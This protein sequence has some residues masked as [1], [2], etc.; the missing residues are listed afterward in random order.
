M[1]GILRIFFTASAVL[2]LAA[3]GREELQS[4]GSGALTLDVRMDSESL[5]RTAMSSDELLSSAKVSIYKGDFTGK[6]REYVYSQ[7]PSAI[8]LPSDDYR[9][10][11]IAGEMAKANPATA[12]WDQK[13]YKGSSDVVISAGSTSTVAVTAKVCNIISSVSFDDS[14][15]D[16]FTDYSCTVSLDASYASNGLTYTGTE[17]GKDGYFISSGFEPSLYWTFTGTL[18]TDGSTFTK[19]GEIPSVESGKRY[20][21]LFKYTEKNGILSFTLMVDDSTNDIYDN[22]IFEAT[23]TGVASS[24]RYEIWAGHFTAH[25]DVDETQYD[26]DNV[27][28]EIRK[29]GTEDDWTTVTAQRD[30]EGSFSA[31]ISGLTPS[32]AYEYRVV[33]KSLETGEVERIDATSPITTDSAP[34]I[35]NGSFETTSNDEEKTKYKSFYDPNSSDT[36][37]QTKWWD[38]GN[39]GSTSVGSSG[40]ICYP[41]I[42]DYKDGSQSVCLQSRY[43]VVKFAAGNLFSGR[44]GG[45][46][47]TKGGKVYFGRPF[48]GR[49]SALRFWMK[50]A[51][52]VIN[53]EEDGVPSEGKK[54]NPD[55]ASIRIALGT[56]DYHDS[57]YG[58]GDPDSPILVN[59]TE[60][61]KFIDFTTDASTIAYAEKYVPYNET[62]ADTW[63]QITL[64]LTYNTATSY[65]TH[66]V[67]SFAA[68]RYGDYFSGYDES[69]LWI[70]GVE[71]I[72]E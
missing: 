17:S 16:T 59:T 22:I 35:P 3:C 33:V 53:R 64:P 11:V 18:K 57:T 67:I 6:V 13:S 32:T 72:Y 66:I 24:S 38:N 40:V 46:I 4:G 58:S 2:A 50:Y 14:V 21:Q 54:G 9:I 39:E 28:F 26:K 47:G 68:S 15:S 29:Q 27:S 37:L 51:G 41:D 45:T 36:S 20:K 1:K 10:D 71:L 61:G 65:P 49:P 63:R 52:G 31:V 62:G 23:S 8:Y 5:T 30:S 55:N 60:P 56:W 42:E 25:A 69:K 34:K 70:D 43:V 19:S 12:S 48:T 7:M 44:F